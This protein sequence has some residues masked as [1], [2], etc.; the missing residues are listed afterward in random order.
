LFDAGIIWYPVQLRAPGK[1]GPWQLG[2]LVNWDKPI[3]KTP[4]DVAYFIVGGVSVLTATRLARLTPVQ[5][6]PPALFSEPTGVMGELFT[7]AF[8]MQNKATDHQ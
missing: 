8:W 4:L 1:E 2:V 6:P 7:Y 3:E 5:I